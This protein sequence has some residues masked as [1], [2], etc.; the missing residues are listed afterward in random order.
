MKKSKKSSFL[1]VIIPAYKQQKTILRDLQRVKRTIEKITKNYEMIIVIDGIVDK[2]F[3]NAKRLRS[4]KV[5]VFGYKTNKGKGYA[6][7]YG[8]ARAKGDVI[9]FLDAGMDLHPEGIEIMLTILEVA[10]ADVV[11]GSKIHPQ[12][13]VVYPWQRKIMSWGYR[14]FVKACFGLKVSDTQ[15]GMKVFRRE[16]LED[17]L[18]RLLVKRYAFDIEILAVAHRLGYKKIKEAPVRITFTNWSSIT[19]TNFLHTIFLMLW[20]TA[21]VYYRL[22]ILKYYDTHSK[23]KW[24]FDP[25]LNFRVNI[26]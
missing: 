8:M 3:L 15:V 17:V 24:K 13:K 20:D 16:V 2:T 22:K 25:E 9:A 18:P 6:V 7:R 1:S 12:S 10:Q 5:K 19:S 4:T 23:R 11:I 26:G 14:R 21:A